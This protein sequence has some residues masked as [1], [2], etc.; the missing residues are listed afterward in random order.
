MGTVPIGTGEAVT[1]LQI[2]DA[3]NAIANGG[4]SSPH[5]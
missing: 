1:P 3:Y 2:L 4:S 5:D